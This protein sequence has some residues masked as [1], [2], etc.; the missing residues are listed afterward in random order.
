MNKLQRKLLLTVVQILLMLLI[1][2]E[3]YWVFIYETLYW[4]KTFLFF[5][6]LRDW[7]IIVLAVIGIA[8]LDSEPQ[9]GEKKQPE[10]KKKKKRPLW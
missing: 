6:Y 2:V 5:R 9:K 1:T 8:V 3:F 7:M 4:G 10:E